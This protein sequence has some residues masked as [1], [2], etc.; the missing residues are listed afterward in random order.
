MSNF[1]AQDKVTTSKHPEMH[2]PDVHSLPVKLPEPFGDYIQGDWYADPELAELADEDGTL[3]NM[4]NAHRLYREG[5]QKLRAAMETRSPEE[6]EGAHF[7]QSRK[8]ADRW[9]KEAAETSDRARQRAESDLTAV[10][11]D[12]QKDLKL[13]ESP[14]AG[15]VRQMFRE[16]SDEDRITALN[17]A[18]E[19]GDNEVMGAVI[20]GSP[21][22]SGLDRETVDRMHKVYTEKHAPQ[23]VKR[24]RALEKA[25]KVNQNASLEA[26]ENVS[27][28]FPRDKMRR[29]SDQAEKARKA[30]EE[31]MNL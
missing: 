26:L 1:N 29:I 31:A 11:L 15:E 24:Q 13:D 4:R 22:L 9:L 19:A 10:K 25:L 12:I 8:I 16:M 20:A 30:R 6:S 17:R 2:A 28:L 27:E 18:I 14:R 23:L 21:M 7:L 3:M 5:L